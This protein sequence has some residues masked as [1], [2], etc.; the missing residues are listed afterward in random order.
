[1]QGSPEIFIAAVQQ[2]SGDD[3]LLKVNHH[4]NVKRF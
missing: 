1:M 2:A 3:G 4:V